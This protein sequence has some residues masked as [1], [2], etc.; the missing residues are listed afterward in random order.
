MCTCLCA[1]IAQ[2]CPSAAPLFP[3]SGHLLVSNTLLYTFLF[4]DFLSLP[5]SP[6]LSHMYIC[7]Y[8]H[9]THT[10]IYI[11]SSVHMYDMYENLCICGIYTYT[12]YTTHI[13]PIC[14]RKQETFYFYSLFSYPDFILLELFSLLR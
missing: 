1:Y 7:I 8:A 2:I 3:L 4:S 14:E 10:H 13:Y 11:Y 5:L 6:S 12:I 9:D